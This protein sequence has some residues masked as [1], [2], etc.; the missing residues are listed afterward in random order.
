MQLPTPSPTN[1]LSKEEL[2]QLRNRLPE[3]GGIINQIAKDCNCFPSKVSR[4]FRGELYDHKIVATATY[5]AQKHEAALAAHVE[6]IKHNDG[7]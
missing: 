6:S 3:R 1:R 4:V 2:R 7:V 5:Y